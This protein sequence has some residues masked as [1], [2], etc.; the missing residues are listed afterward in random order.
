[1]HLVKVKNQVQFANI[2]EVSIQDFNKEM[3]QLENAQLIVIHIH[4]ELPRSEAKRNFNRYYNS[5]MGRDCP[6]PGK[7]HRFMISKFQLTSKER[8]PRQLM[9]LDLLAKVRKK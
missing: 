1:M 7:H 6:R 3:D 5:S 9:D 4:L 8:N 2:S